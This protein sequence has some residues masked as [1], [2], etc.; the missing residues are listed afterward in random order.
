MVV[1]AGPATI[2]LVTPPQ[3]AALY[4]AAGFPPSPPYAAGI[5]LAVAEAGRAWSLLAGNGVPHW[6][7]EDG[8]I[9]VSPGD[10]SGVVLSFE[11]ARPL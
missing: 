6:V 2:R 7:T 5:H 4:P 3:A 11:E 1:P 10:A 9:R 8:A